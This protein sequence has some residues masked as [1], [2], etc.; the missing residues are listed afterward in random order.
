MARSLLGGLVAFALA[1]CFVPWRQSVAGEGRIVAYA[2]V[3]RRQDVEAP[4]AGRV[5][6]VYVTE[7]ALVREGDPLVL[8]TDNDPEILTRMAAERA[9]LE[10]RLASYR[11]RAALMR[12]R[13]SSVAAT[14]EGLVASAEARVRVAEQRI[15]TVRQALLASRA[16]L[17][18]ALLQQARQERLLG[19]GLV[20]ARDAELT[21]LATTRARADLAATEASE[22]AAHSELDTARANLAAARADALAREQE[23]EGAYESAEIDVAGALA[24]LERLDISVARQNNQ[25]VRAPRAGTVYRVHVRGGGEQT[26]VGSPLVTLVPSDVSPAAEVWV[27][28]NDAPLVTPGR[29]ARVQ[30]EGWP[31]VQ[32]VGWP[33]IAAGTFSGRVSVVDAADDGEGNFRVL[34][35]PDPAEPHW[36]SARLLRQGVRV[37]AFFLLGE[38]RLGFEVWRR[39][40]GFPPSMRRPY[41]GEEAAP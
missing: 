34:V 24:A 16:S 35:L 20:S 41:V 18:T 10:L 6:A 11:E 22:R 12:E 32:F 36:P 31:A 4:V 9:A 14:Q 30:F 23:A 38:V 2:P 37:K 33:G 21:L 28:G 3:D 40:N 8:V 5:E 1:L 15:E 26:S 7:G 27:D 19:D 13:V 25:I 17:D 29:R 39:V